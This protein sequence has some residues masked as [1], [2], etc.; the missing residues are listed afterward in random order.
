MKI[1]EEVLE[2]MVDDEIVVGYLLSVFNDKL[3]VTRG[4]C[5]KVCKHFLYHSDSAYEKKDLSKVRNSDLGNAF[6]KRFLS[7]FNIGYIY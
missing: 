5:D 1:P 3:F 7:A 4:H 2:Q 6:E